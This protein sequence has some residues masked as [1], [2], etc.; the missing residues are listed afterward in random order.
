MKFAHRL[1]LDL[2]RPGFDL[3]RP[4][5]V[6]CQPGRVAAE[7]CSALRLGRKIGLIRLN[8]VFCGGAFCERS[9]EDSSRVRSP[10]RVAGWGFLL[11]SRPIQSRLQ[12]GAPA[13]RFGFSRFFSVFLGFWEEF[14]CGGG[15]GL[16]FG[17]RGAGGVVVWGASIIWI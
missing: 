5:R 14:F 1:C 9:C 16:Q 11:D 7:Q 12:A 15:G 4:G 8:S 2:L 3:P 13:D 6:P 17:F 10:H